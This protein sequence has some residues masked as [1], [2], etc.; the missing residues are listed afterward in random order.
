[1]NAAIL[2][3]VAHMTAQVPATATPPA[4]RK[5]VAIEVVQDAVRASSTTCSGSLNSRE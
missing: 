5:T 3:L 4:A 2:I 1:M